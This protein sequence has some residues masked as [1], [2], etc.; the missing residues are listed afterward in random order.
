MASAA[1]LSPGCCLWW[2]MVLRPRRGRQAQCRAPPAAWAPDDLTTALFAPRQW[3]RG[4]KT[5]SGHHSQVTKRHGKHAGGCHWW[6]SWP[7]LWTRAK[8]KLCPNPQQIMAVI[9]DWQGDGRPRNNGAWPRGNGVPIG[10]DL[11]RSSCRYSPRC[12]GSI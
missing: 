5:F 8:K 11:I 7:R 12:I 6:L 9:Q 1:F 4:G 10:T 2:T 3:P